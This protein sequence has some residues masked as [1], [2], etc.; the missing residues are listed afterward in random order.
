MRRLPARVSGDRDLARFGNVLIGAGVAALVLAVSWQ[1][2]LVPGSRMTLPAPVAL[3]HRLTT[4]PPTAAPLATAAPLG[5]RDSREAVV[6]RVAVVTRVPSP[7][8]PVGYRSPDA[9][10]RAAEAALPLPGY[11]ARLAIPSIDLDT[12]VE[13]AG[14]VLD[15]QGAPAWETRPF[16]A[17]HYGDLTALVGARGNAVIAGHVATRTEGNVF[18]NLYQV[19]FGDGIQVWDEREQL[20]SFQV[21]DVRLV[22]PSDTSVMAP[23]TERTLTLI[24]CGGTFDPI[25]HEFSDRLIVIAKAAMPEAGPSLS[26]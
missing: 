16:V 13:Q 6:P 5:V 25:K 14:I 18:R 12:P 10:H 9:D 15:P 1:L 19:D 4:A 24:T 7:A 20:H 26:S 2:G 17:V 21:V 8:F 23:T 22:T 3:D 11:A